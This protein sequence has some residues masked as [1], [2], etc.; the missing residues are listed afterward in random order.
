MKHISLRTLGVLLLV[1]LLRAEAKACHGL[2]LVN[3]IVTTSPTGVT[4]TAESN[5]A[6]CGCGPV[7]M[8]TEIRCVGSTGFTGNPPVWNAANI[9]NTPPWYHSTLNIPG[10]G[11]PN[12]LDDCVPEPYNP[13]FIP[14][15]DLCPGAS[16]QLRSRENPCGSGGTPGP[17]TSPFQFTTPGV[18]ASSLLNVVVS[19]DS[20]CIGQPVTFSASLSSSNSCVNNANPVFS[21][22]TIPA[23]P[24]T[25]FSGANLTFTPSSSCQVILTVTDNNTFCYPA[26]TDTFNV[27]V[28]GPAANVLALASTP[29]CQGGCVP[30]L[31][32]SNVQGAVQWEISPNGILWTPIPGATTNSYLHCPVSALSYF[33]V[34][35]TGGC[36]TVTSNVVTVNVTP[37]A[38]LSVTPVSP[39]ICAGQQATLTASGASNYSWNGGSLINAS[40][41]SQTVSPTVTTTYTITGNPLAA[42]PSTQTVTVIV[43]PLPQLVFTPAAP[44]I[45]PGTS[46]VFTCGADSNIY[47]WNIGN[48]LASLSPGVND[49]MLCTPNGSASYQV[50]AVSP[51]GCTTNGVYQVSVLAAPTVAASSDSLRVCPAFADTV[52]FGGALQYTV[53]P[54]SG[55]SVLNASGSAMAFAPASSQTYLIIGTDSQGCSD[56]VAVYVQADSLAAVQA[57]SSSAICAGQSVTLS[58]S[59]ALSYVW[60]GTGILSGGNTATPLVAPASSTS[61]IV[62]GTDADGCTGSDTVN[63]TVNALPVV[64]FS[65]SNDSVC[66]TD[67]PVQLTNAAPAG[68]S[69]SGTAVSG[70]TFDPS[71]ATAG[72][73]AIAYSYTDA[74]GC[75]ATATDSVVVALCVSVEENNA[76]QTGI[77]VF[78]NPVQDMFTIRL[79]NPAPAAV[80][81]IA[82]DGKLVL[83]RSSVQNEL[84]VDCSLWA[85]GTYIMR[86]TQ[87]GQ[88]H[89]LK[90]VHR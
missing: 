90:L 71:L 37:V 89:T 19:N 67:A 1:L 18:P 62:T 59:G 32:S 80:E 73:Y 43:N 82:A 86:V 30:L 46:F 33:R 68:G 36:N 8:E 61:Y 72:V 47:N 29:V 57:G 34:V 21:W 51:G 22:T 25:P 6:S 4:I 42:C 12:W 23:Q 53:S 45:C 52:L 85:A 55:V 74:N 75:T 24:G 78:P 79:S 20:V 41:A 26:V 16:Y 14:Y 77:S 63:I 60:S 76:L 50:T 39:V 5:P 84:Q 11:P 56:T 13:I 54:A 15:S 81:V 58:A 2:P 65:I 48:T 69:F 31:V 17:W 10:Y 9:W 7:F 3:Y 88:T 83:A 64:L 28:G 66:I 44:Q 70:N 49:S 35:F 87:N 27:F 38:P 40:G